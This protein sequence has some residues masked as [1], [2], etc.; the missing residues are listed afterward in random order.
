MQTMIQ[1]MAAQAMMR[2]LIIILHSGLAQII[3][4]CSGRAQLHL[5]RLN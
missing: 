4:V 3:S 1:L 2:H 5:A